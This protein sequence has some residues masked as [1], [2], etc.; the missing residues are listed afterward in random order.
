MASRESP[1]PFRRISKSVGDDAEGA[2]SDCASSGLP[3]TLPSAR[4]GTLPKYPGLA[5]AWMFN[6]AK[7]QASPHPPPP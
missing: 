2:G 3:A 4:E 1:P 7:S 5:R 6:P